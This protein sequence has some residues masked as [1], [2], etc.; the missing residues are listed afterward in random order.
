MKTT[1]WILFFCFVQNKISG[2]MHTELSSMILIMT[3]K[4]ILDWPRFHNFLKGKAGNWWWEYLWPVLLTGD[5]RNWTTS[6]RSRL[7]S[8]MGYNVLAPAGRWLEQTVLR[9]R[10]RIQKCLQELEKTSSYRERRR[11]WVHSSS[12]WKQSLL[13]N[14]LRRNYGK[15][16]LCDSS[17]LSPDGWPQAHTHGG[18]EYVWKYNRYF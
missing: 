7:A 2:N 16:S 4:I 15:D 13:Q 3:C 17:D 18:N 12:G 8:L 1:Y 10:L 6:S 9:L 5:K 14:P 11:K